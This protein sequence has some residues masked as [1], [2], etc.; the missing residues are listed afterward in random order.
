[1]KKPF[2]FL[3]LSL[4]L[5]SC[6]KSEEITTET[7]HLQVVASIY[8]LAFF[9]QEI[10]GEHVD[11][12]Q[13]VPSGL[14]PHDYEP[15]TDQLKK[16][17]DTDLFIFNGAG[18]EPWANN[19]E[20]ELSQEDVAFFE[21]THYVDLI[22]GGEE[23]EDSSLVPD[24]S[25]H[26]EAEGWDPHVW[27][28]PV[29]AKMIVQ[30]MVILFAQLDSEHAQA[31]QSNAQ[32][33]IEEL[34]AL[35]TLYSTQLSACAS[36]ELVTSH[37]AFGYLASRYGLTMIPINGIS[38]ENEASLK[39][40]EEI[41]RLV[42]EHDIS[43]IYTETLVDASFAETISEETGA[44]LLTLNPLEGL[45]ESDSASGKNYLTVMEDNLRNLVQGLS[46]V[47]PTL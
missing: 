38:P 46:C 32:V 47:V 31:Y 41:F 37:A 2:L 24:A 14:E 13:I 6:S 29:R 26:S 8:P 17:Y 16:V 23:T 35:D 30:S 22:P 19:L 42:E 43:T 4:L 21:A 15:T 7:S 34:E 44:Q 1:M 28:D 20:F 12:T 25:A 27:L 5:I 36:T 40:L 10:G 45:T 3:A 33:L 39:D 18:L 9:A 11:I